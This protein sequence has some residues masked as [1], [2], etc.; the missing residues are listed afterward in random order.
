M[1][2]LES[3]DM[4]KLEDIQFESRRVGPTEGYPEGKTGCEMMAWCLMS[5][6]K[7]EVLYVEHDFTNE[8]LTE[9]FK[10]KALEN[11]NKAWEKYENKFTT[12]LRRWLRKK[13][14]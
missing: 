14:F 3:D 7:Q 11:M 12:K 8:T 6:D 10:E 4:I 13:N 2:E 5:E 9:A 1:V